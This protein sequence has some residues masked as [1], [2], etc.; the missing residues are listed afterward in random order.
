MRICYVIKSVKRGYYLTKEG[1]DF[2][3]NDDLL[4]ALD[5]ESR[6]EAMEFIKK[7]MEDI[8]MAPFS[9]RVVIEEWIKL[10]V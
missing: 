2:I 4:L 9:Y 10:P 5:F 1:G 7:N 6:E 8:R 3:F